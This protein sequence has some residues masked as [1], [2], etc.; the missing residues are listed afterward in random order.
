MKKTSNIKKITKL[1]IG[2]SFLGLS[3]A[4]MGAA[5]PPRPEPAKAST[6]AHATKPQ[7]NAVELDASQCWFRCDDCKRRCSNKSGDDK[8]N[9]EENCYDANTTCCEANGK[10]GNYKMCGCN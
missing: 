5:E 6:A 4:L 8:Q 10:K 2:L 3:A 9:C 1:A 7:D